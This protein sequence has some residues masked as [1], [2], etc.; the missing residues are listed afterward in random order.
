MARGENLEELIKIHPELSADGASSAGPASAPAVAPAA[1]D[2]LAE[3]GGQG[4]PAAAEPPVDAEPGRPEPEFVAPK[5]RFA[6]GSTVMAVEASGLGRGRQFKT[7]LLV[8]GVAAAV[9]VA[10]MLIVSSLSSKYEGQTPQVQ[11]DAAVEDEKFA[12]E[13]ELKVSPPEVLVFIDGDPYKPE[14]NPPKLQGVRAGNHRFKLVAPGYIPWEG[15]MQLQVNQPATIEQKLEE[16]IGKVML[17]SVPPGAD[18]LLNGKRVGKTPRTLEALPAGKTHQVILALKKYQPMKFNIEPTEWPE[19]P[20]VEIKIEKKLEK[21]G[22]PKK[23][24]R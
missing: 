23:R 12:G 20:Q 19:G 11:P 10:V 21:T 24:H 1:D 16:R 18:I 3:F 17:R 5:G 4:A 2:F 9:A 6:A 22:A 13:V 15:E 14:G 8:L 7:L